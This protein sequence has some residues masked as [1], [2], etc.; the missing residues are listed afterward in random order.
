MLGEEASGSP[1]SHPTGNCRNDYV[2]ALDERTSPRL[3]N[4][5]L[6]RVD[7]TASPTLPTFSVV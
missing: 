5:D 3:S 6:A 1:R 4:V 2:V 7:A